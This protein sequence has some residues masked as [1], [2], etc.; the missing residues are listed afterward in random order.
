MVWKKE[1]IHGFIFTHDTTKMSPRSK[2]PITT[3][4]HDDGKFVLFRTERNGNER[5]GGAWILR[6]KTHILLWNTIIFIMEF[7]EL[8]FFSLIWEM[9]LIKSTDKKK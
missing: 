5:N 4:E 8:S 3:R 7:N 2:K 6:N 1:E 9:T